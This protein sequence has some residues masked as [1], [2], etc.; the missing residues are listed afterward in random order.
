MICIPY[1]SVL[2]TKYCKGD[3]IEKNEMGRACCT[4]GGGERHVEGFDGEN[5]GKETTWES[6]S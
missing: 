5:R 6:Q 1:R 4:C 2:P 3:Q